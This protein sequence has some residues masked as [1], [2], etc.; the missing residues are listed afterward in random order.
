MMQKNR[1]LITGHRRSGSKR[2]QFH[3]GMYHMINR[4]VH[5]LPCSHMSYSEEHAFQHEFVNTQK[6]VFAYL[7]ETLNKMM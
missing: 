3:F 1:R 7:V 5:V 4:F 2:L 6:L